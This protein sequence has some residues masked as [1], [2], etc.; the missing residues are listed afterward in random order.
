MQPPS[1]YARLRDS[2]AVSHVK[3]WDGTCPYL[4]VKHQDIV[5]VL[6]DDRLSKHRSEPGFPEMSAG[7]KAAAKNKPTFVDMDAPDHMKQRSMVEFAF[8]D[9]HVESLTPQIQ[10]TADDLVDAMI[11]GG[12]KDPVDF[13]EQY[14]LPL[15]SYV[16]LLNP[17]HMFSVRSVDCMARQSMGCLVYRL[18]TSSS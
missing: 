15:P 18:K 10:T 11:K 4:V 8:S 6:T 2:D 7:G 1:E 14:A 17:V 5:N 9:E 16:S 12:M 13:V 3:L